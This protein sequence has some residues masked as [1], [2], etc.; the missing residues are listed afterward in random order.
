[1]ILWFYRLCVLIMVTIM[2]YM[3][4]CHADAYDTGNTML[5]FVG[6]DLAILSIAS[7]REEGAWQAP[8]V[9]SVIEYTDIR[10]A[11]K[12]TLEDVLESATGFHV[13]ETDAGVKTY[14]RGILD[15]ALFLYDTMPIGSSAEKSLNLINNELPLHSVKRIEIVRGPG[16]VLW[17]PDAFAGIVNVVSLTGRDLNGKEIGLIYNSQDSPKGAY[18]NVGRDTGDWNGFLSV[19][20]SRTEDMAFSSDITKFWGSDDSF[21]I[22]PE[23]RT[24]PD[25]D[26]ARFLEVSGNF[27]YGNFMSVSG[28]ISDS[29]QPYSLSTNDTSWKEVRDTSSGF[30]KLEG[31]KQLGINSTVRFTGTFSQLENDK[32]IMDKDLEQDEKNTYGEVSY[33]KAFN[34]GKSLVTAGV[35]YRKVENIGVP[36]WDSYLPDY[37]NSE[38]SWFLPSVQQNDYATELWSVFGQY[39]MTIGEVDFLLG[40]RND[41]HDSFENKLSYNTGLVWTPSESWA[42]KALLGTAYRTPTA[43]QLIDNEIPELEEI[44]SINLEA[45]W[46]LNQRAG[47]SICGFVN[48]IA[49]HVVED[50]YAGLSTPNSQDIRGMELK[51]FIKPMDQVSITANFTMLHTSGPNEVYRYIEYTTIDSEGN[52]VD[53]WAEIEYPY[54]MGPDRLFNLDVLWAPTEK[55]SLFSRIKY[56]SGYQLTYPYADEYG[57]SDNTWLMD[58]GI[59]IRDLFITDSDMEVTCSNVFNTNYVVP[60][61]YSLEKGKGVSIGLVWRKRW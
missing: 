14:L 27:F 33:E 12:S 37:L 15:S 36:I 44:K 47:F 4:P 3:W 26:Y 60:G 25:E 22:P 31:K 59:T 19:S 8:A 53:H 9:V 48:K 52:P 56:F 17:G 30:L 6:E 55:I 21:P 32:K 2:S 58:A 41:D 35:S 57:E 29:R 13:L 23:E 51:A 38:N 10:D 16:S 61:T 54:D 50:P 46:K 49:N 18:I 43:R 1:M 40:L 7:G 34:S 28:R 45:S 5:M 11:H 42:I 24:G 39:R 20:G